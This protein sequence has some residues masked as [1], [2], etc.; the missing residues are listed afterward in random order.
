VNGVVA[1]PVMMAMMRL[2]T[3][4]AIMAGLT[5]PWLL[6]VVGWAATIVMAITVVA[7]LATWFGWAS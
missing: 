1:V 6:R 2:S 5:L 4:P 3:R 7:M